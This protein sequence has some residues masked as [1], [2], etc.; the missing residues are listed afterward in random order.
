M[1]LKN[2]AMLG[3]EADDFRTYILGNIKTLQTLSKAVNDA[4][5]EAKDLEK[6]MKSAKQ[7]DKDIQKIK[8]IVQSAAKELGINANDIPDYSDADEKQARL[9]G[10]LDQAERTLSGVSSLIKF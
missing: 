9:R 6:N 3:N 5:K 1:M 8:Q 4:K 7:L 10:E 2:Y